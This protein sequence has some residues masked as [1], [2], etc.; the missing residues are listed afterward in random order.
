MISTL[1][2]MVVELTSGNAGE[3]CLA[4]RNIT[5]RRAF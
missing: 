5:D 1:C 4:E 2:D 3:T